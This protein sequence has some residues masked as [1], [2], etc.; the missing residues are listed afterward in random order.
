MCLRGNEWF[1]SR[2]NNTHRAARHRKC[3]STKGA[4]K[5]IDPGTEAITTEQ[6][7]AATTTRATIPRPAATTTIAATRT[8]TAAAKT[9][10][11]ER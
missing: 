8:A 5:S 6:A 2:R 3:Q 7:A 1:S 9:T 4:R 11:A 10:G